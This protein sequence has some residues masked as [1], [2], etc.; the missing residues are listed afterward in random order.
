M[1]FTYIF[2]LY[3]GLL[4]RTLASLVLTHYSDW[5]QCGLALDLLLVLWRLMSGVK[6]TQGDAQN[7]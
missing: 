4:L 5:A 2:T 6:V 7:A 3:N 1:L